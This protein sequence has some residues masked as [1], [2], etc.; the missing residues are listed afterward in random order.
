MI[1]YIFIA[2]LLNTYVDKRTHLCYYLDTMYKITLKTTRLFNALNSLLA[3]IAGVLIYILLRK[4]THFHLFFNLP[5]FRGAYLEHW[6]FDFLRF[7]FSDALWAY[8]LTHALCIFN[9]PR[10]SMILTILFG[11]F[12]EAGQAF[13]ILGG[14]GDI[15]DLLMYITASIIAAIITT[16]RRKQNEKNL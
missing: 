10:A 12:W 2:V 14:T 7:Y 13:N 4:Q 1:L 11:L 3:L 15:L 8:S 5:S 16:K 9:S 6:L